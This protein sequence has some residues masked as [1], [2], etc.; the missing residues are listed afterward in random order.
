MGD[1]LHQ[2]RIRCYEFAHVVPWSKLVDSMERGEA[3]DE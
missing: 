3:V 1:G 2:R